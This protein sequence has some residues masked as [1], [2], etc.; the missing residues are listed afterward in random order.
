MF[1]TRFVSL[2]T[3]VS[4]LVVPGSAL[5][6]EK[7]PGGSSGKGNHWEV[8]ATGEDCGD[9]DVACTVNSATPDPALCN[10]KFKGQTAVCWDGNTFKGSTECFGTAAWCTYKTTPAKNCT[11]GGNKGIVYQCK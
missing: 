6:A 10:P 4:L 9:S 8:V 1:T 11:G 2:V 7:K 3:A 5:A